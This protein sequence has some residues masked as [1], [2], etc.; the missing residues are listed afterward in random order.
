MRCR[1]EIGKKVMGVRRMQEFSWEYTLH[2]MKEYQRRRIIIRIMLK[3]RKSNM[4][5]LMK[6]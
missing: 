4:C 1:R 2:L 3:M 6:K 5:N